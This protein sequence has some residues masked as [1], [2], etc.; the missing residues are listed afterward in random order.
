MS[1]LPKTQEELL[2]MLQ[3]A[4]YAGTDRSRYAPE[5]LSSSFS[6]W[7]KNKDKYNE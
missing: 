3:E 7:Y 2:A 1:K 5:S 6:Y 4:Y